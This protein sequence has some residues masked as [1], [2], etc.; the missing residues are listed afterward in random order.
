MTKLQ[1]LLA[2]AA[3]RT[4]RRY[5]QAI[6]PRGP[7]NPNGYYHV[8]S[9]GNFG[10]PLFQTPGEHELYLELFAR[11]AKKFGWKTL[12]WSLVWNHH[13]FLI[14]LSDDGLSEGMRRINH[15]FSR[16]INAAYG[17]TGKGHLV[18]HSF[19]AKE[20]DSQ[21]YLLAALR[22]IDLNAVEAGLCERPEDWRWC[23]YAATMGHVKP[24]PFHDIGATLRLFGRRPEEARTQYA[25][26][27]LN[28][29]PGKGYDFATLDPAMVRSAA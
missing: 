10:Q 23:G 21:P 13:H 12:A 25:Q 20:I 17:R 28:R 6:P 19:F 22:Y 2:G 4:D 14:K 18:R 8:S 3:R 27:V 24:R 1:L 15:G 26:F 7:I 9:R 11:Y 16:R 5:R 29:L